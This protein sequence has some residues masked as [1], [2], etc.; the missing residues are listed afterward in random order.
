M[1]YQR[2]RRD[3]LDAERQEI[4]RLRNTGAINDE[5]MHRIE[6]DLETLE[7]MYPVPAGTKGLDT[8][9]LGHRLNPL[10]VRAR[11][12]GLGQSNDGTPIA[13][14]L[15]SSVNAAMNDRLPEHV[16]RKRWR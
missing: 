9:K 12:H 14:A 7:N 4:I 15:R 2:L 8:S 11:T 13:A 10:A 1:A 16:K 5:L 6:R 3:A